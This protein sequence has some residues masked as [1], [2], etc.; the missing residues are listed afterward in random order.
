MRSYKTQRIATLTP[1]IALIHLVPTSATNVVAILRRIVVGQNGSVTSTQGEIQI[2]RNGAAGSVPPT[3]LDDT[4]ME[5]G[6]AA[7]VYNAYPNT[8]WTTEPTSSTTDIPLSAPMNILSGYER[9]WALN[10]PDAPKIIA[11]TAL[12]GLA[13]RVVLPASSLVWVAELTW[14]EIG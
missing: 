8:G 9:A 4:Q 10:D 5:P 12:R 14:T 6:D 11:G 2:A 7:S 1:P 3:V 13:L